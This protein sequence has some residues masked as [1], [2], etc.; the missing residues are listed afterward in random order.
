MKTCALK[1]SQFPDRITAL[2]ATGFH[3]QVTKMELRQA[4]S[5]LTSTHG[6]GIS[7]E[8]GDRKLTYLY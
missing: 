8:G 4:H 1:T 7:I 2:R 5:S 6:R 3:V